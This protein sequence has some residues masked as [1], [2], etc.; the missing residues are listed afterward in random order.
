MTALKLFQFLARIFN[1]GF[2]LRAPRP[3][4]KNAGWVDDERSKH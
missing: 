2:R 1:E 3:D 4:R